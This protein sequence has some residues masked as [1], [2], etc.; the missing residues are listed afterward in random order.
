MLRLGFRTFFRRRRGC[1]FG[2][3]LRSWLHFWRRSWFGFWL[4]SWFDFWLRSW[5]GFWLCSGLGLMGLR[6]C[7][8]SRLRG[9]SGVGTGF[10]GAGW[11]RLGC[12]FAGAGAAG[13]DR[14][15]YR[16]DR[17]A[18]RDRLGRNNHG[19]TPVI[20]GSKLLPVLCGLLA[21]LYLRC[22][23]RDSLFACCCEFRRQR[24]AR[25]ASR[26]SVAGAASSVVNRSV[27]DDRIRYRAVV[28]VN[29]GDG[30]IVDRAVVVETTAAPITALIA[31]ACVAVSIIDATVVTN[32]R[33]PITV[34]VTIPAAGICPV[35]RRPQIAHLG[36][37]RPCSRHPVVPLIRVAPVSGRPQIPVTGTI[38]L[39]IL[40]WL[41]G[42]LRDSSTG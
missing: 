39:G 33:A 30:H 28:Y 2:L 13:A 22:H 8:R 38:R 26:A 35:T 27:V 12:S 31:G 16:S 23:R 6:S 4:G 18:L 20:D 11:A 14:R 40:R 21:M 42:R 41:W 15:N 32:M 7:G 34:I 29:V 19:R 9:C 5:L 36:R 17:F 25:H 10:A 1:W 3:W 37:L 24:T